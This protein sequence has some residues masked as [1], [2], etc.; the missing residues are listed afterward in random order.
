MQNNEDF[1]PDNNI[2]SDPEEEVS[3][4]EEISHSEEDKYLTD[5]DVFVEEV[6]PDEGFAEEEPAQIE[7]DA[8]KGDV[9][10][11]SRGVWSKAFDIILWVLVAVLAVAV[12]LRT[13]V[14]G[15]IT[16]SGDSMTNSY[17]VNVDSELTFHD[18][19]IVRVNKTAKPKRGDVV[20]FYKNHVDSKFSAMFASGKDTISGGKYEKLIKRV[21]ALEGDKLWVERQPD[22][23][24]ALS[25]MTADGET[26]C[27]DYYVRN[28]ETLV[29]EAFLIDDSASSGLGC[30]KD[31]SIDNCYIVAEGC[32][33][34]MGDNR[35][36]S[37]DSRGTL[38]A[39]PLD[40]MYGVVF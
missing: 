9:A 11:T 20:V 33:F 12:V 15:K 4:E 13:F 23:R 31:T 18:K 7:L 21:V 40:Q 25:I 32:F 16:V 6:D 28:G 14:F 24:Y 3:C 5:E 8:P 34:A 22:G 10:V 2:E 38:G 37:A 36:N 19:D 1:L 26:L 27:E 17:Y 30:L 35:G 29:A 39:V